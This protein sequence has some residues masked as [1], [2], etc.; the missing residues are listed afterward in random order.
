MLV[1]EA[2]EQVTC[3]SSVNMKKNNLLVSEA[4]AQKNLLSIFHVSKSFQVRIQAIVNGTAD[5]M[6][7][8]VQC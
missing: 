4:S 1:S 3:L 7:H 6:D 8:I 5:I 2:S